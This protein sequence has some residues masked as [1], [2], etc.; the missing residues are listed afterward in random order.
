MVAIDHLLWAAP[1]L[2]P[3][4]RLFESVTGI[5]PARGGSH[6]G[7]GTRNSLAS[8]DREMYFEIIAPDPAQPLYGNLGE[9]L[10]K[11]PRSGLFTFAIKSGD[12]DGLRRA[13]EC[14]GIGANDVVRMSRRRPDGVELAW[15]VL[16]FR[17]PAFGRAIPFAIDWDASPHPSASTPKGCRL[18]SLV[19]L[20]PEPDALSR[21]YGALGVRIEVRRALR[22][23][24]I[25][26][27]ATP[28][29]DVVLL[30]P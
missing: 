27:L 10:A 23:G 22:P 24:F 19:A 29:G 7:F 6:A 15:S 3:A 5:A 11:L 18:E 20:S 8:L 13:A 21:L 30:D 1:D 2:D 12:L 4:A 17:H 16:H 25:A 14:A 28:N 26:V 9:E